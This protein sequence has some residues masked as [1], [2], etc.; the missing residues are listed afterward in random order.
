MKRKGGITLDTLY[1]KHARIS[2]FKI[3]DG[4]DRSQG[5][6]DDR[7]IQDILNY[8]YMCVCEHPALQISRYTLELVQ[9]IW[10]SCVHCTGWL[11][12]ITPIYVHP[13]KAHV[14]L[15]SY[16]LKIRLLRQVLPRFIRV[17]PMACRILLQARSILESTTA[18]EVGAHIESPVFHYY[19]D[20]RP[21]NPLSVPSN[22]TVSRAAQGTKCP[23]H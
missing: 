10:C 1:G 23:S 2:W 16:T 9:H 13:H 6:E 3:T 20:Y 15:W 14:S 5:V 19:T 4:I 7:T 21:N 17:I 11:T 12:L 8:I 18:C 22:A